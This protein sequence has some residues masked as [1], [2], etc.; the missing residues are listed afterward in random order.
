M[1]AV[2]ED[3]RTLSTRCPKCVSQYIEVSGS[4]QIGESKLR[5]LA[6][7]LEWSE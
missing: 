3:L 2:Q 6:C 7:D 1:L 4:H 5:C